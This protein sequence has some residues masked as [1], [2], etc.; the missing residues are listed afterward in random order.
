[1]CFRVNIISLLLNTMFCMS[2]IFPHSFQIENFARKEKD[3]CE[4][5]ESVGCLVRLD[6][7]RVLTSTTH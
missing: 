6:L 3:L 2:S 5:F 7:Q 4:C 1:M